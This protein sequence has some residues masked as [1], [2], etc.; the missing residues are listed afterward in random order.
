MSET[1]TATATATA[2]EAD[3]WARACG[4]LCQSL[5]PHSKLVSKWQPDGVWLQA[6]PEQSQRWLSQVTGRHDGDLT[7][8]SD[9]TLAGSRGKI[10][11]WE[12]GVTVVVSPLTEVQRLVDGLPE[13]GECLFIQ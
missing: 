11:H 6:S 7:D 8:G 3:S 10:R 2:T 4:G 9:S 12:G 5:L 13:G 1:E